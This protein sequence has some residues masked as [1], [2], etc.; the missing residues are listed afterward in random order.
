MAMEKSL[1]RKITIRD[2]EVLKTENI[3]LSCF[4]SCHAQ[5][6]ARQDKFYLCNVFHHL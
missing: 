3:C 5:L 1:A 2:R 4:L 6:Y